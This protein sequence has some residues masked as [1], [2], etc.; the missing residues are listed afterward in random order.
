MPGDT[1]Q[2]WDKQRTKREEITQQSKVGGDVEQFRKTV[3]VSVLGVGLV[4]EPD[5]LGSLR[6]DVVLDLEDLLLERVD[7]TH[8]VPV[9]VIENLKPSV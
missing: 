5:A 6:A 7:I 8:V 1:T 2:N 9:F 3:T 4:G